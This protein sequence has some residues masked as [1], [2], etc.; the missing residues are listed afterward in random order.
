[1]GTTGLKIGRRLRLGLAGLGL[2]GLVAILLLVIG[3]VNSAR[4]APPPTPSGTATVTAA[5]TSTATSTPT[6]TRP[7]TVAPTLLGTVT[8]TATSTARLELTGSDDPDPVASG[9]LLTY[10]LA[11]T[12]AGD[13]T[14]T[15]VRVAD[16]LD[17]NV[18]YVDASIT[19]T[20]QTT[21]TLHWDVGALLPGSAGEIVISVTVPCGLGEGTVLTNT[22]TLGGDEIAPRAVT[23]TTAISGVDA[24]CIVPPTA[25][26]TPTPTNTPRPAQRQPTR[27]NTPEPTHTP[28]P[29]PTP[30]P[31]RPSPTPESPTSTTSAAEALT[32]TPTPASE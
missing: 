6:A 19:P 15:G 25:T 3:G 4:T 2:A 18:A 11:Y 22:A 30:T 8:A 5:V 17:P 10:T 9:A 1:L 20:R 13:A 21:Y 24:A 12:N 16:T 27:T 7:A 29:S 32:S 26:P 23:E 28:V 14:A 31:P